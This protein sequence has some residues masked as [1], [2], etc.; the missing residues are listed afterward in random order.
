MHLD[1]WERFNYVRESFRVLKPGGRIYI[2]NVDLTSDEGWGFFMQVAAIPPAERPAAVSKSSTP[3]ELETF[4][5]RAGFQSI[6]TERGGI[7]VSS[8]AVKSR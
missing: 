7:F 5:A 2:D 8:A 6:T 3:I 4:L 1:E